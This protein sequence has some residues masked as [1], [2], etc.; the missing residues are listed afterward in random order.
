MLII[1]P[2]SVAALLARVSFGSSAG[3]AATVSRAAEVAQLKSEIAELRELLGVTATASDPPERR[4]LPQ[5]GG[6]PSGRLTKMQVDKVIQDVHTKFTKE[7]TDLQ[8]AMDS[9]W[10]ILCGALVMFMHPG[11]ALLE[12]GCSR[13][14]NAQSVLFKNILNVTV[15]SVAWYIFGFGFAYGGPNK[16]GLLENKFIGSMKFAGGGF[17][18]ADDDGNMAIAKEQSSML[19]WFFQWAF[20]TAAATIVSGAVAQ[21]VQSI[22]YTI[23]AFIMASFI[24]PVIVAWTWGYGWVASVGDVGYMDFAGSGIVHL[25]GGVSALCGAA[26]LGCRAGWTPGDPAFAP[27][28]MPLV[29]LGTFILWFG[30]YGFNCGSTLSLH[31]AARGALASQVAM[32]TTLS[33]AIG[34]I[35][36]FSIQYAILKR[37]DVGGM[38]NGI[39]AGLVSITAGCGNV[40]SGSAFC[41]GIIGGIIYKGSSFLVEKLKIDDPVDAA[42]VHGA[43]G[44][45]GVLAA[46]LFDWGNGFD[47]FHGWSGFDCMK[48]NGACR[49][50]IGGT[51][52]GVNIAMILAI[53]AWAGTLSSIIFGVMKYTGVLRVDAETEE[54]GSDA[55]HHSPGKAYNM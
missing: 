54:A 34:G 9:L 18:T 14:K 50:G 35:T 30:W 28:N 17:L 15:G 36:V 21:R 26:I 7:N 22:S 49:D 13:A 5:Y 6:F 19:V 38:C 4:L 45:W 20:C 32:N 25:T 52:L 33:A 37:Y 8:A 48:A 31:T 23:Y 29:V 51:V 42:S 43:C 27:H 12:T 40:E 16:D 55:K 46:A 24:Y 11:F 3:D 53:I 44:I 47:H 41:I 1:L 39:L 10:L 2:L